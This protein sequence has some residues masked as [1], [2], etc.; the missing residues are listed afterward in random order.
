MKTQTFKSLL[1]SF[2]F[3]AVFI[4][5]SCDDADKPSNNPG[6]KEQAAKVLA[7]R[8][9]FDFLRT[10]VDESLQDVS[11]EG[12]RKS[13]NRNTVGR[14]KEIA[15]CVEAIEEEQPDG[16]IRVTM[17]FGDGCATGEGIVLSGKAVLEISLGETSFD[18][19][20]TFI[21]YQELHPDETSSGVANGTTTGTI[22][23]DMETFIFTQQLNSDLTISYE[24][25]TS[26]I[27]TS[28][29]K[30][31]SHDTGLKLTRLDASGKFP[32][33]DVFSMSLKN[34]LVY[35]FDCNDGAFPISG[36][37]ILH[38]NGHRIEVNYGNGDCDKNYSVK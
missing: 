12:G 1:V 38:F 31:E 35:D 21:D 18:F 32:N 34:P 27:F 25:N 3:S 30:L 36:V 13:Y 16:S 29:Q 4:L 6:A 8:E 33:G 14:L 15:P 20:I 10:F 2:I 19:S 26:A 28:I 11:N 9:E 24:D 7:L 23:I 37:E 5:S 22:A 17:N